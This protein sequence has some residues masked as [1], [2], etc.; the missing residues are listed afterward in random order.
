MN[1]EIIDNETDRY[2][3]AQFM[4]E[5]MHDYRKPLSIATGYFNVEGYELLRDNLWSISSNKDLTIRLLLGSESTTKKGIADRMDACPQEYSLAEELNELSTEEKYARLVDDLIAFLKKENV[6]VRM[7]P[8]RFCHAKT[9]IFENHVIVGSSNFTYAGLKSNVELNAVLYQP[10]AQQLVRDWFERR[11]QKAEPSKEDLIRILEESKFGYPLDPYTMYM[12]FLY[13]YYRPRLEELERERGRII[14]LTTFQQDAVATALRIIKKY[15]GVIVADSTGLGK[16]HIGI[17]LL[18]EFVAVKR[19]KALVIAPSQILKT[20]WEGILYNESIKT[21]NITMESTGTDNFHPEDYLDVDVVLIDESH[22]YRN[23]STNR[24]SSIAKLLAGGKRKKVI[25]MTATPVNNSLIDLYHQLSLITARDDTHFAE[26]GI[27]DLRKHFLLAERKELNQGIEDIVRILDETM[28]RRTRQF[29]KEN[30]PDARLNDKPIKFPSRRIKKE[31]YSLTQLFGGQV[32]SQVLDAIERLNLVPYRVDYYREATEEKE[33][34]MA[35]VR[36]DLQKVLLLKRFESSVEAIKKSITRLIEFYRIFDRTIDKGQILNSKSFHKMLMD[37]NEDELEDE[38]VLYRQLQKLPLEPLTI[39]YNKSAM[40]ADI[41]ADLNLL[42]PLKKNLDRINAYTD[43]K[44]AVLIAL[45]RSPEVIDSG[46]RKCI[47]FTQYMDTAKYVH[48]ELEKALQDLNKNVKLLTGETDPDTRE[49][50]IKDF[51]PKANKAPF[52]SKPIDIL[53]STDIL[54]E[55][56][57]LQDANYVV[58]YDLPWNPMKIVQRVGRV[59]RLNSDFDVVTSAVFLPE[60]ELEDLLHLKEKLET[61]IQKASETV[62]VEVTILGE[63]ENPRNFNA[64]DRIR[65]EDPTLVDEM[66]R[67]AELLPTMTPF[68]MILKYIKKMGSKNLDSIELEKRS[69]KRSDVDGAI[70]FYRE[71]G[72]LEGMHLIYYDARSGQLEHYNDISW[73]MRKTACPESEELWLPIEYGGFRIFHNIDGK[74]RNFVVSAVNAPQDLK[75][76]QRIKAK[77][78]NNLADE[79]RKAHDEGRINSDEAG[80]V[81]EILRSANLVAWEDDFLEML[82]DYK[83][84]QNINALIASIDGLF[85]KYRIELRVK[86]KPKELVPKNLEVVGYMF[87]GTGLK[88]NQEFWGL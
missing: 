88:S 47:V 33:R 82:D 36:A 11:W 81:Y 29:I 86:D 26:L 21:K 17:E 9:Y 67:A 38:E 85:A 71:K 84:S 72:S 8:N 1:K 30:Y 48:Q 16:T 69:G 22:N 46:S 27:A 34:M 77:N 61:K 83:R 43:Q 75:G 40:K 18:R 15:G 7:N 80:K 70:I 60:K 35:E 6:Q 10:S 63:K 59:D 52:V 12:K 51:A 87:L 42:E 45:L 24:Y 58:N 64:L 53:V 62:G 13:E 23:A 65:K 76:I 44:L 3:L 56:Q 41:K 49:R 54:S 20:V 39:E 66:E 31:E 79:I 57:N 4:N 14:E 25:L 19:M 5:I 37:V 32:Y 78:Q 74:A 68:Q 50:I 2:V 73:L 55:G 28:I